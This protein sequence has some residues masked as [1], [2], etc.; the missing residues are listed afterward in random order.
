MTEPDAPDLEQLYREHH[1]AVLR[2]V[3][4]R[5]GDVEVAYD[6]T[7]DVF[8]VA[9]HRRDDL[10]AGRVLPWLYRVAANVLARRRRSDG[11][12]AAAYQRAGNE[13]ATR[14]GLA[15]PAVW[16]SPRTRRTPD[17]QRGGSQ[18][19]TPRRAHCWRR[20]RC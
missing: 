16:R 7:A 9:W 17:C 3:E 13:L 10:P 20:K 14:P 8:L 6:V 12:A 2:Y 11:R 18:F 19:S 4:R 15:S 1:L 5:V